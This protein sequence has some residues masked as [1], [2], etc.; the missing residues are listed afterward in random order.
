[1]DRGTTRAVLVTGAS[2][3]IGRTIAVRLA[4]ATTVVAVHYRRDDAMAAET[5][6]LIRDRGG[7]AFAVRADFAHDSGLDVLLDGL[8]AGLRHH[9]GDTALDVLVNNAG[10]GCRADVAKLV[11]EQ[12]DRVFAINVCLPVFLAQ[13]ALPLMRDGGRIVNISSLATRV[14]HPEIVGYAMSKGALEV[15]SQALAEQL[16]PRGITV[17]SVAPGLIDTEFHGDRLR[18]PGT[19]AELASKAALGRIG[20]VDDVADVVAFLASDA[21]RWITGQRIEVAGGTSL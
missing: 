3:G 11:P 16:G 5:V 6:D 2:R 12:L 15:F 19:A 7:T 9:T 17:N 14:A 1:M 10:V 13:R 8:A 20:Q 4:T 21:A 18:Q